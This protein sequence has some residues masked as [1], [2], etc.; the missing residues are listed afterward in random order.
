MDHEIPENLKKWNWGAFL[1][2]WI[3]GVGNNTYSAFKVFIP[4]YGIYYMFRLGVKGN[5]YAWLNGCWKSEEHFIKVQRNWAKA[6]IGYLI[7]C[8]IFSL[9]ALFIPGVFKE[10]EPYLMSI[11]LLEASPEFNDGVGIPYKTGFISGSISTS[12][13]QG[14]ANM[15]FDVRGANGEAEILLKASKDMGQ[16]DI[17]CLKAIYQSTGLVELFGTCKEES[18]NQ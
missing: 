7:F 15:S 18:K 3:W 13:H 1:L 11:S 5:E 4:F 10:S 6:G 14:D 2:H 9:P 16:W 8:F 17:K 12:G